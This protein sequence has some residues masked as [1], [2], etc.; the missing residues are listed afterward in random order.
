M[1]ILTAALLGLTLLPT[2]DTAAVTI[3]APAPKFKV[4]GWVKGTPTTEFK[5]GHVYVVEFWATWCGPCIAVFPHLSDLSEKYAGKATFIGVNTWDY[6]GKTPGTKE[7][8]ATHE[9][10]VK[11]FVEENADKMR[12]TVAFDDN[13]D[14]MA[15]TWMRPAGQNGIPSAFIVDGTGTIAWIGHPAQMDEPLAKIVDNTWDLVAFK[16]TFED[17]MAAAKAQQAKQAELVAAAKANDTAKFDE[18]SKGMDPMMAISAAINANPDF[19]MDRIEKETGNSKFPAITQISMASYI[20]GASKSDDVKA[21]AIKVCES[22]FPKID[23]KAKAH[24]AYMV[25]RA[26]HGAGDA[27][28]ALEWI[29]KAEAAVGE[30]E[31]AGSR[32]QLTKM[33]QELKAELT[34][35]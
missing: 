18:L 26:H 34:K 31:P 16:K 33:I 28:T 22:A 32:E 21:R 23:A 10:R 3:G 35:G 6:N 19:A 27:K 14:F 4:E 13:T 1:A 20:A 11:K 17:K 9:A 25:A 24:G 30:F 2:I 12:Y 29:A 5:A 8:K 7:D 15:N